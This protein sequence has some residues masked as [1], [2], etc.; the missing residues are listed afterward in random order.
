MGELI[1]DWIA[2]FENP[3][4]S[5]EKQYSSTKRGKILKELVKTRGLIEKS[6]IEEPITTH[7]LKGKLVALTDL[8]QD[9]MNA[10]VEPNYSGNWNAAITDLMRKAVR[11]QREKERKG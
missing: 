5:I 3:S 10:V 7:E 8:V 6:V 9:F 4:E 11:E 1:D 2:K